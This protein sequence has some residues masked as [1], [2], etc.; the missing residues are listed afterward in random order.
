MTSAE[1]LVDAFGRVQETVHEVV[2]GLTTSQLAERL[3]PDANSIVSGNSRS[4]PSTGPVTIKQAQWIRE[5]APLDAACDCY[6][7]RTFSRAYLRHLFVAEELL[8]YR[9]LTL[10]NVRF[11]VSLMAAM[12]EAI[13]AGAFGAFRARF[14]SEYQVS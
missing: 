12:R 11:Y 14:F 6:A 4:S 13:A 7:C 10:H 5:R 9:L 8:A 1:I 3:G 2:R